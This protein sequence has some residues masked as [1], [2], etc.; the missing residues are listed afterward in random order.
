M[1]NGREDRKSQ[2]KPAVSKKGWGRDPTIAAESARE[3][4]GYG[5][6]SQYGGVRDLRCASA[7]QHVDLHTQPRSLIP[8][9]T[10]YTDPKEEGLVMIVGLMRPPPRIAG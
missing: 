6:A 5:Y 4:G 1:N 9:A 2:E 7:F 10:T 3:Y 8:T